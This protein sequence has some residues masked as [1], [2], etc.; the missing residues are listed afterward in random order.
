MTLNRILH[1]ISYVKFSSAP[2]KLKMDRISPLSNYG[3]QSRTQSQH[4]ILAAREMTMA[5]SQSAPSVTNLL[6]PVITCCH[7]NSNGS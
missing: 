2:C 4:L 5:S 7:S 3:L 1:V 6:V